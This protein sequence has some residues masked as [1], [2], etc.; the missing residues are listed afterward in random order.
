[1]RKRRRHFEGCV[2]Y[3]IRFGRNSRAARL[4]LALRTLDRY[5]FR[6]VGATCLAVTSVLLIILLSNQLARVLSQA[7]ANDFPRHVVLSLIALTSAGNLTV[8]V[9]IGFFLAIVLALGRLYHESEMAAIQSCGVGPSGLFRP[10]GVLGVIVAGL[11]AWLSFY[12]VPAASARAQA[13]RLE[14][15][16]DAQFGAL[17]PGR[18]RSFSGGN[19]VFYAER[20]DENGILYNVNVFVDRP[21]ADKTQ[22]TLEVWT[23]TRAEQ[24]GVGQPEQTFVLYDGRR[25]EGIP[26]SGEFRIMQFSEGGIPVPLGGLI[27]NADKPEMKTTGQ[28]LASGNNADIAELQWRASTPLMAL[29]LML[30]AVPLSKLR[31]RQGR[32]GKIGLAVLAYFLYYQLL[33]AARAWVET[34]SVP[35]L[36][37]VWWVHAVALIAAIFLLVPDLFRKRPQLAGSPA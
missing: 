31:P 17:E 22:S 29:V 9:P 28:L 21:T 34:G 27:A 32:F 36:L 3:S 25:Y 7:A 26:G 18:F 24:R 15:M 23:A 30:I 10:I 1:M 4:R 14:A 33:F 8:I 12:A 13:I 37:G 20:V 16:R 2:V 35:P 5:V 11:L 6:E 19:I